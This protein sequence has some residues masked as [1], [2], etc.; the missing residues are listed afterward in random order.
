M[1]PWVILNFQSLPLTVEGPHNELVLRDSRPAI[2]TFPFESWVPLKSDQP[3]KL[4]CKLGKL[5]MQEG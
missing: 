5:D 1:D 3:R 4:P 2:S